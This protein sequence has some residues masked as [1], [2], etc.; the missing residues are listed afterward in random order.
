MIKR[1]EFFVYWVPV[2]IWA[3]FIFTLSSL[4][5]GAFPVGLLNGVSSYLGHFFEFLVLGLIGFRALQ[6]TFPR[7]VEKNYFY[8]GWFGLLFALSDE[9]HQIFVATRIFSLWDILVD[10]LGIGAALIIIVIY[11][12]KTA[13]CGS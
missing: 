1:S 3:G 12:R 2:F 13:R 11:R 10:F 9:I 7:P 6:H 5:A 8:V 4:S